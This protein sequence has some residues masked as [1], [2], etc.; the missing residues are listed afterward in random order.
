MTKD[1][2]IQ[3]KTS[4]REG[5]VTF[6]ADLPINHKYY[7]KEI[8]APDLYYMSNQVYEF[9]YKYK[10]DATYT[11]TFTHEFENKEVRGE[12][13]VKKID[14]DTNDFVS[15]EM[16]LLM[17]QYMVYTLRKI[18]YIQIKNGYCLQKR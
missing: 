4:D 6:T 9:T 14:K 5:N 13:H 1:T 3:R 16:P 18:S 7:I 10:D 15:Q 2:L 12:V 11:Y 17:V 8:Q